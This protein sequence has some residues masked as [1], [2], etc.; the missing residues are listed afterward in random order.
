MPNAPVHLKI[1]D[2]LKSKGLL[3][4]EQYTATLQLAAA[5]DTRV[6]EAVLELDYLSEAELLPVLAKFYKVQF[7]STEKLSK[8]AVPGPTLAMIP[9]QIAEA[10]AVFPVVFDPKTNTLSVVTADPDNVEMLRELRAVSGAGQVRAFLARPRAVKAAIAHAHN[11]DRQAFARLLMS[12][13]VQLHGMRQVRSLSERPPPPAPDLVRKVSDRPRL[14]LA[15]PPLPAPATPNGPKQHPSVR[16]LTAIMQPIVA[17]KVAVYSPDEVLELLNVLIN[18]LE[19]GRV[20][21]RGHSAHVAR[22]TRRVSER[23]ALKPKDVIAVAAAGFIHDLGKM[24]TFHL[25]A[26]NCAEYEGHKVAAQKSFRTPSRL[27]ESVKITP[28]TMLAVVHMYERHDGRGFPDGLTG[29]EI[30]FGARILSIVDTYADLTQN[31]R[32]PFRKALTPTEAFEALVKLKGS[33]FDPDL[34]DIFHNVVMGEDLK[35]R[36]LADRYVV[37]LVD[38]DAEETTVLELRLIEQG[39]D[40]R[41][42]RTADQ[43]K[44]CL[45][46]GVIDVV[47]SEIELP[48]GDGLE[49]LA[50]ARR[51]KW[52]KDLAWVIHTRWQG[53]TEAQRAFELGVIDFVSK[54]TATD[55]LV[56]KLKA[57]LDSQRKAA[58]SSGGV[59]GS[60]KEM[61]L[62]DMIQVLF[63][64]RKTGNLKIRRGN[65]LGEIHFVKGAVVNALWENNAGADAFYRLLHLAEG[66]LQFDP[67]FRP[68]ETRIQ[69]SVE[70]LLLEGMRRLDEGL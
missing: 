35:A 28:E 66:D 43:A 62:P 57:R 32:N 45:A 47:I 69:E 17:E 59:S 34:V 21:L 52:G 37:L 68:Q 24:G 8:A 55:L 6:E 54:P 50:Q 49:L 16:S 7:V 53:R 23:M 40:V 13:Q 14:E 36:L 27:L 10:H 63:H 33:V 42:A 18:L 58:G 65:D 46:S 1:A 44:E 9:K 38:P 60:L 39:F 64:G 30:P 11:G 51:E 31:P 26:L 5:E 67:A 2:L 48:G 3:S 19:N 22:L 4:G 41:I 61:G 15:A 20:D 25:T 56:A 70:S 12:Q 29:K